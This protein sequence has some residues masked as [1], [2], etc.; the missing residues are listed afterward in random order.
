MITTE[1]MF[2]ASGVCTWNE[3]PYPITLG[4]TEVIDGRVA[5]DPLELYKYGGV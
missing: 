5:R 1:D 4:V 3:V 2:A